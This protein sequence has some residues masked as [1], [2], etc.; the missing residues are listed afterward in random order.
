MEHLAFNDALAEIWEFIHAVNRYVDVSA[1]WALAKDEAKKAELDRVL[2]NSLEGLRQIALL[3]YPYM[4]ESAAKI[5][6][7]LGLE[8]PIESAPLPDAS[9]WGLFPTGVTTARGEALFPR[10]MDVAAEES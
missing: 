4:P 3:V 10:K 7:H 8:A 6:E 2:Y 9:R 5:W 1:P